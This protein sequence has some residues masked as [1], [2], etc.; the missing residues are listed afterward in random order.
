MS[1]GNK[2]PHTIKEPN[3]GRL[4]IYTDPKKLIRLKYPVPVKGKQG[5]W[6]MDEELLRDAY[7]R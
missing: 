3:H 2:S 5:L 1:A 6:M 7:P 4:A